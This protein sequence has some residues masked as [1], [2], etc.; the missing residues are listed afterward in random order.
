[1]RRIFKTKDVMINITDNELNT[2]MDD[3]FLLIKTKV[4]P[5]IEGLLS[6][7]KIELMNL[8]DSSPPHLH[9]TNKGKIS[10]GESYRNLPFVILDFPSVFEKENIFAYRT[11][12]WWG[13]FFSSTLH[14]QGKHLEFY[15]TKLISNFDKLL[16]NDIYIC[17]ATTPWEYHY[18]EDN[19]EKLTSKHKNLILKSNFI[20]LSK[21]IE[22]EEF[23][24]VPKL[25]SDFLSYLIN[26][27][28]K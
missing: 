20:K 26:I 2:I 14:L 18:E 6:E 1:M 21:K 23:A 8:L 5:K 28:T 27:L 9:P 10:K 15:R 25:T 22:L 3:E 24:S 12:F 19:Y 7:S 16:K 17:V 13:N 11:M 4:I